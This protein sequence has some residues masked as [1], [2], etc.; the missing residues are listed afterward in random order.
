M[1]KHYCG[2]LNLTQVE[3][4]VT[5]SGWVHRRRDQEALFL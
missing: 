4:V 2:Q 5:L 3:Q 1:R